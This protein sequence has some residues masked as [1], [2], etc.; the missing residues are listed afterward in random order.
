MASMMVWQFTFDQLFRS[1]RGQVGGKEDCRIC[2]GNEF[3]E[4]VVSCYAE[5]SEEGCLNYGYDQRDL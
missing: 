3:E 4:F 2:N 5:A 1:E